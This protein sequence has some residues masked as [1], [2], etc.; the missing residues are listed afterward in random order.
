MNILVDANFASASGSAEIII[1]FGTPISGTTGG[2][3]NWSPSDY[4]DCA[5]CDSTTASPPVSG[6][7]TL[8]SVNNNGCIAE[9]EI[10]ITVLPDPLDY[11]F[12]PNTFTPNGDNLNDYFTAYGPNLVMID[13][14][15]IYDRWGSLIF[16]HEVIPANNTNLGWDGTQNGQE[17]NA[18]VYTYIMELKFKEGDKKMVSGNITLIR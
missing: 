18:G 4:V 14:M 17:V 7:I 1:G 11:S 16:S 2:D 10:Y 13:Y 8:T 3:Y 6:T 12:I 9:D 5:N 15:H